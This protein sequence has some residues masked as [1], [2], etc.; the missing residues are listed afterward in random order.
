M[1]APFHVGV[2]L[3]VA[4]SEVKVRAGVGSGLN[5]DEPGTNLF[6][7]RNLF[8]QIDDAPAQ[9]AALDFHE[10]LGQ[11]QAIGSG[12]KVRHIGRRRRFP[13]AGMARHIRRAFE[14]ERHRYLQDIGDLLQ[15]A[16]ADTVGALLVFLNLLE[17]Q[18]K[19]I[20]YAIFTYSNSPD[21]L[22]I[23]TFGGAIQLA[24]L[25]GSKFSHT[26]IVKRNVTGVVLYAIRQLAAI[27]AQR[28]RKNKIS[29]KYQWFSYDRKTRPDIRVGILFVRIAT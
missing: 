6:V 21:L 4:A 29:Y 15:P 23:P 1:A 17:G 3:A 26:S 8:D 9:F 24:N 2:F 12:E 10:R 25:L 14:E 5:L 20:A 11:R 18:A 22:S 7:A 13:H 27:D 16:G 28:Q 19:G